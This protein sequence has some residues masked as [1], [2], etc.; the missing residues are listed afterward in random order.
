MD[1]IHIE[2]I[3]EN[4]KEYFKNYRMKNSEKLL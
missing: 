1:C 4:K 3:T 2:K